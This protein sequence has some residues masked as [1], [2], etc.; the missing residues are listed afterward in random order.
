[1]VYDCEHKHHYVCVACVTKW[2]LGVSLEKGTLN[3]CIDNVRTVQAVAGEEPKKS[4]FGFPTPDLDGTLG[5]AED[6]R[7]L[8]K[9]RNQVMGPQG[10]RVEIVTREDDPV[11]VPHLA[12]LTKAEQDKIEKK[13]RGSIAE[14]VA[15]DLDQAYLD[16]TA[17]RL[18]TLKAEVEEQ[19]KK[20]GDL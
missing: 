20:M 3:T 9:W 12:G 16:Q 4:T 18:A 15:E 1:L 8:V 7:E 14:A 19:R 13:L 17:E 2:N 10:A 11:G 5:D 6:S